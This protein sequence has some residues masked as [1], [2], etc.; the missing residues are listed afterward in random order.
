MESSNSTSTPQSSRRKGKQ[1]QLDSD[2][3]PQL[4]SSISS[5]SS[6]SRLSDSYSDSDDECR[7]SIQSNHS[8]NN[9]SSTCNRSRRRRRSNSKNRRPLLLLF[10]FSSLWPSSIKA[11]NV[12]L[13]SE[14]FVQCSSA[15]TYFTAEGR[16]LVD[17]RYSEY[18]HFHLKK[19]E[20][21]SPSITLE[22]RISCRESSGCDRGALRL[23]ITKETL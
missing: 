3:I 21:D 4:E 12:T 5:L 22:D 9:S 16:V 18:H 11:I 15:V 20:G 17:V 6:I 7:T 13:P 1:R 19:S 14:G 2:S 23:H 10:L 8:I